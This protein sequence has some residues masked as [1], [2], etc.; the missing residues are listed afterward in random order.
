MK[1][2]RDEGPLGAWARL[3]I[4][5][6]TVLTAFPWLVGV[7][8]SYLFASTY[9]GMP[10][11]VW[12]IVLTLL[13]VF[14]WHIR[15]EPGDHHW[16]RILPISCIAGILV[17][18]ILG[19]VAYRNFYSIYW[20]YHDSHAYANVL[21]SEPAAGYLDAGKLVFAEEARIDA[22]K[23]MSFKDGA[24]Y[25]VA[26]VIDASGGPIQFWA[27][28]MD[29]CSRGTFECDDAWDQ[30]AHAGLVLQARDQYRLAVRQAAAAYGLASAK[31]PI[32]VQWVVDPEKVELNYWMLG[33]GI[34]VGSCL[35]SLVISGVLN[36][37]LLRVSESAARSLLRDNPF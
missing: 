13:A 24:T 3:S 19:L 31:E 18:C 35:I 36:V 5:E 16:Q 4:F 37:I 14:V 9:H 22:T 6:L 1:Q 34:L 29:C 32:F 15:H 2:W 30:K 12:L 11:S 23:G 10:L 26:P 25:C 8:V 28:G 20:L 27:A 7:L 21:P 33:N 17:S